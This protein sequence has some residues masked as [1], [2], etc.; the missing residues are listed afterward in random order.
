MKVLP[1]EA[2][3]KAH[4]TAMLSVHDSCHLLPKSYNYCSKIMVYILLTIQD[5]HMILLGK[6]SSLLTFLFKCSQYWMKYFRWS[7]SLFW[8]VYHWPEYVPKSYLG[9]FY[10]VYYHWG[11]S[12]SKFPVYYRAYDGFKV[13]TNKRHITRKRTL[14]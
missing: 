8:T 7:S 9:Q 10:I 2:T 5:E 4:E 1:F 11:C 13:N 12:Q 14:C 3:Q 6:S